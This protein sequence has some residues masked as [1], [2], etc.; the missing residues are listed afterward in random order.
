M[1][2]AA[3]RSHDTTQLNNHPPRIVAILMKRM[4]ATMMMTARTKSAPCLAWRATLPRMSC[5]AAA[6]IRYGFIGQF[7][8]NQIPIFLRFDQ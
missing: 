2:L 3:M 8:L 5:A 7:F 4:G 6:A 1:Y